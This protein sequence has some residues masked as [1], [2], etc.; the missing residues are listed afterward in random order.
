MGAGGT[1]PLL[2]LPSLL[3][4]IGVGVFEIDADQVAA[5]CCFIAQ[6]PFIIL[7]ARVS[8]ETLY[9]SARQLGHLFTL[10][11]RAKAGVSAI[12]EPSGTG[13]HPPRGIYQRFADVLALEVLIPARGLALALRR[14]RT[15]LRVS[16]SAIGDIEILYA[17]RLFGVSFAALAR[18]CERCGLLPSGAAKVLCDFIDT[19]FGGPE[20]RATQLAL[21]PAHSAIVPLLPRG[22]ALQLA[23]RIEDGNLAP[24]VA[25]VRLGWTLADCAKLQ[26]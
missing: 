21:P 8:S 19:R 26:P 9:A 13:E 23:K 25:A 10:S 7:S 5:A 22:M 24:D 14:I 1:A 6:R 11:T 16:Q 4:H 20:A 2:S 3:E 12:M 17:S 18:R 15:T